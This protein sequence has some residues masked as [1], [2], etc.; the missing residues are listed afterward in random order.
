MRTHTSSAFFLRPSFQYL[1]A[2]LSGMLLTLTFPKI[3]WHLLVWVA[4][5]PLLVALRAQTVKNAFKIGFI[6]GIVHY[7]TLLHWLVDTMRLYGGLPVIVGGSV[8]VLLAGYLA[9]FYAAFSAALVYSTR[10]PGLVVVVAPAVWVAL[11]YLR[12]WFLTGFPWELLGYSQYRQVALIQIADIGGVYAISFVIVLVNAAL[13]MLWLGLR[14]KT[15]QG[16]EVGRG[17]ALIGI[18]AAALVLAGALVYGHWRLDDIQKQAKAASEVTVA[19]VQGNIDQ[20]VKWDPAYQLATLQKYLDMSRNVVEKRPE[21]V[22]WPETATPFY[23]THDV[24]LTARVI[25]LVEHSGIP[26][27]IGSQSIT[28]EGSSSTYYNSAYL[29]Q[30]DGHI[31][32]RYDKAHLVPFGEYVPLQRWLPFLGKM[33]EHVGDFNPGQVGRTL[34]QEN[35]TLGILIC[36]ESIFAYSGRKMVQNNA[37]LLV[38]MTNDAW[39][40]T[41]SGPYQHFSKA[42]LRAVET[43]RAL[44]RVANTGISAFIEPDGR[45]Y[46][47]TELLTDATDSRA[48]PLLETKTVYAILGDV[49]ALVCVIVGLILAGMRAW[50]AR[51]FARDDSKIK[52]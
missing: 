5:L 25:D 11:E 6:G 27:L 36:Y 16:S 42:V 30:P 31:A 50:F 10:R 46:Q 48:L 33:V 29:V 51:L 2:A 43:R 35:L 45:I 13:L 34:S 41:S 1:L 38:V 17:Q 15:W 40:G 18:A 3:E 21:L 20:A 8:L 26:F 52:V 4:L 39:Y 49:F 9:L 32:A 28:Q 47:T 22:V 12:S 23:F 7:L 44:V 24:P 19:F 37:N 14:G